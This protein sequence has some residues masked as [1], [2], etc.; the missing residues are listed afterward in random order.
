MIDPAEILITAFLISFLIATFLIRWGIPKLQQERETEEEADVSS[1]LF[2]Y[3]STGFWIGFFETL[4][5][6][7]FVYESEYGAL[8]IIIGAKEF[9]RKEKIQKN[10]SYYLLGTLINVSIALLFAL[11]ARITIL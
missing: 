9:V 3:T 8:A 2:D 11:L 4:L 5:V 7:V 6:F 10:P 1:K